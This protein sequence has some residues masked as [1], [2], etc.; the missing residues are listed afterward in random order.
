[1]SPNY[2]FHELKSHSRL[3]ENYLVPYLFSVNHSTDSPDFF[4][5]LTEI[6][7]CF[8]RH[9][10]VL[11]ISFVPASPL[12]ECLC[13][14][15]RDLIAFLQKGVG[16][17]WSN[18]LEPNLTPVWINTPR[19]EQSTPAV[20]GLANDRIQDDA[21]CFHFLHSSCFLINDL[22]DSLQHSVSL[23]TIRNLFSIKIQAA[24]PAIGVQRFQDF[25]MRL[26][27]HQ[28][29]WLK[30]DRLRR[31]WPSRGYGSGSSRKWRPPP[32][33]M[34]LVIEPSHRGSQSDAGLADGIKQ[35]IY[36]GTN[37]PPETHISGP[38]VLDILANIPPREVR[39]RVGQSGSLADIY[40]VRAS[41]VDELRPIQGG[42]FSTSGV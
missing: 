27:P 1:M 10:T 14:L 39:G 12:T 25:L 2:S 34:E 33:W 15:R 30:I 38:I 4:C 18:A 16:G 42:G 21:G 11:G 7:L 17:T 5:V 20:S 13:A 29:A 37:D 28:F 26:D 22:S 32:Q 9:D 24:I 36:S 41:L 35:R 8:V 23:A 19:A 3:P 6:Q 40:G 31:S